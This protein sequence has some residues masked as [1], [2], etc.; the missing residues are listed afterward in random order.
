MYSH[1]LANL[2]QRS[3]TQLAVFSA[4][5]SGRWAFAEPLLRAGLPAMIGAQGIVSVHGASMFFEKLY[6]SVAVGLSLDEALA[7][8]RFQLLKE[9]GFNGQESLEWG[10]FMAYMPATA[11]TLLARAKEQSNVTSFQE[12]VRRDSQQA[13]SAV[14]QQIGSAPQTAS[15]V[16]QRN[17][18]KAIV[19]HFSMDEEAVLCADVKQ[20]LAQDGVELNLDLDAVGGPAQGEE[21]MALNL[22][23]YLDRRGYLTYLVNAVRRD[24]PGIL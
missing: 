1:E 4:C 2:L 17:L 16:D 8:A 10:I 24:R 19:E 21:A 14:T 20:D 22:I 7:A 3:R 15:A 23:A 12:A 11:A 18:R 13:I 6:E 5:N 9:G